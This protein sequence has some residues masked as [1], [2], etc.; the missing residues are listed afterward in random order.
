M[1]MCPC[2]D[3]MNLVVEDGLLQNRPGGPTA[4][5]S[6]GMPSDLEQL[7]GQL[8]TYVKHVVPCYMEDQT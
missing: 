7:P 6:M 3:V 8:E 2:T 5:M 4:L 1:R